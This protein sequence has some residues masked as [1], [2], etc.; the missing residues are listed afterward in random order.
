M[1]DI[2]SEIAKNCAIFG[3]QYEY[4]FAN[5]N[6]EPESAI[7]EKREEQIP[8][9]AEPEAQTD[10]GSEQG[11]TTYNKGSPATAGESLLVFLEELHHKKELILNSFQQ[12]CHRPDAQCRVREEQRQTPL[13]C[14]RTCR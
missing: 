11:D 12:D 3:L 13:A 7:L 1:N 9:R 14:G 4:V 8:K 10:G 2:D 6:A 5:E